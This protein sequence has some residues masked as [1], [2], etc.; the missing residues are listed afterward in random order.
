MK[1]LDWTFKQALEHVRKKRWVVNP[2]P[3]FIRQLKRYETKLKMGSSAI[4]NP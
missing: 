4:M 1:K 2:N 3:G